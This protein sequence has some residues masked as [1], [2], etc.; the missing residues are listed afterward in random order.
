MA[1]VPAS[2]RHLNPGAQWPGAIADKWGSTGFEVLKDGQG[3]KIA[4]FPTWE[5]GAAAHIDL[6]RSNYAGMPLSDA[7]A[8]W[9]GGN[10][11]A[12][13]VSR[14]ARE[15]GL[16]PDQPITDDLLRSPQGLALVKSMAGHEKGPNG[17]GIGDD[18]WSKAHSMVFAGQPPSPATQTAAATPTSQGGWLAQVGGLD[19]KEAPAQG[20]MLGTLFGSAEPAATMPAGGGLLAGL[21]G[22]T[23]K[24]TAP[25]TEPEPEDEA[26]SPFSPLE[27]PKRRQPVDMRRVAAI[28]QSRSRLGSA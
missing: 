14:V 22:D 1:R 15:T 24:K 9:S 3:N 17:E 19:A 13:Y 18:A 23:P 16:S 28:L 4:T 27:A 11:V 8:K 7:I 12:E 25:A 2:V 6:L 26:A 21:F 10:N 20:G 5:Q